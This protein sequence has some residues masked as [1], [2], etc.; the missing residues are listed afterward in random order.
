MKSLFGRSLNLSGDIFIFCV[1]EWILFF[2]ALIG[3]NHFIQSNL[4]DEIIEYIMPVLWTL[5]VPALMAMALSQ[6]RTA[7][8]RLH[9][10][11][12]IDFG[13]IY[14][15]VF[16]L[17]RFVGAMAPL[18]LLC[19]IGLLGV[20]YWQGLFS[21]DEL[22]F[23]MAT[24]QNGE[25]A[26]ALGL[27]LS[28]PRFIYLCLMIFIL[29]ISLSFIMIPMAASATAAGERSAYYDPFYGFGQQAIPLVNVTILTL[30]LSAFLLY[31]DAQFF[32]YL[33]GVFQAAN[34]GGMPEFESTILSYGPFVAAFIALTWT[35]SIWFS[36]A[37]LAFIDYRDEVAERQFRSHQAHYG[38]RPD[39]V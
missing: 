24:F 12:A 33:H 32:I 18:V 37:V 30:A 9:Q 7:L 35:S 23:I 1:I 4:E 14:S 5:L 36:A 13:R 8:L 15:Y 2:V 3:I 21:Y 11:S 16:S 22:M 39:M 25:P 38:T 29:M 6:M 27:F 34:P 26:M 20:M 19:I 31:I 17:L 28:G 10:T